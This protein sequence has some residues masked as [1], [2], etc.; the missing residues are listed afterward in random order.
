MKSFRVKEGDYAL[1]IG[2]Q[3]CDMQG[4]TWN[5]ISQQSSGI[6]SIAYSIGREIGTIA[7]SDRK[8]QL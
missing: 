7:G 1:K 8:G 4:L 2:D 6:G 3:V 5:I